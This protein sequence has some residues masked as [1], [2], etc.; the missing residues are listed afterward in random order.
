MSLERAPA[1]AKSKKEKAK[2][3]PGKAPTIITSKTAL[4]ARAAL[5]DRA[6][7]RGPASAGGMMEG[8]LRLERG[9]GPDE[10]EQD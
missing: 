2:N 4:A 1:R 9:E 6:G 7:S 5:A 3:K 8:L 10:A